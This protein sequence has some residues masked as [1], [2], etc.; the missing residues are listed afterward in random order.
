MSEGIYRISGSV[1]QLKL[2]K[3]EMNKGEWRNAI[4]L[5]EQCLTFPSSMLDCDAV[6]LGEEE[7][8][9]DINSIAGLLKLYL[10]ELPEPLL[11]KKL[12]DAFVEAAGKY[13]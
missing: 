2:L 5:I 4:S 13:R 1:T 6:T 10:R 3:A 8:V 7:L 11:T 9:F 12:S